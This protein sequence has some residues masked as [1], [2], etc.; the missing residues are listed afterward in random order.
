VRVWAL[1]CLL[2][3]ALLWALGAAS[4]S[5]TTPTPLACTDTAVENALAT[6]GDYQFNCS[7][8]IQ[9]GEGVNAIPLTSAHDTTIS[10]AA[11][12]TETWYDTTAE[13][14]FSTVRFINVTGGSLT[15]ND[16]NLTGGRYETSAG[17]TGTAGTSGT[18]G[19]TSAAGGNATTPGGTG[20]AGAPA[21]GGQIL[22]SP[23]AAVTLNGGTLYAASIYGGPGGGGGNGGSGG[24]GGSGPLGSPGASSASGGAGGSATAGGMGGAGGP[25]QGGSIYVSAG[26]TLNVSG[27]TFDTDGA[28]GGPGGSGGGGGHGGQ[29][30]SGGNDLES[31]GYG[32]A[33]GGKA[34]ST[35]GIGGT[36]GDAQGG[37]I[38]NAGT[39]NISSATFSNDSVGAAN[40]GNGGGGGAGGN[41]GQTSV[42]SPNGG[43]GG[44]A[45][46]G[47]FGGTGSGGAVYNA[48]GGTMTL[49][50]LTFSSDS[51]YGGPGGTG[52]MGGA[53]GCPNGCLSNGNFGGS[54][55]TNGTGGN[56][57]N[58]ATALDA[59]VGSVSTITGCLTFG[60]DSVHP[61]TAGTAGG[62]GIGGYNANPVNPTGAAGASGAAGTPGVVDPTVNG[63]A[64]CPT[65][66]VA[67]NSIL[68]PSTGQTAT[69]N[70][71]VTLSAA[72]QSTTT[73]Q[74]TTGDGSAAAGTDYTTASGTATIPAGSTTATIPVT[75][76][77]DSFEP[78]KTFTLTLTNPSPAKVTLSRATATGTIHGLSPLQVTVKVNPLSGPIQQD[79]AGPT[80][81]NATATVTLK[82]IGTTQLT[83]V[84]LPS[85]LTIGWHSGVSNTGSRPVIQA[86]APMNLNVGTLA[87]GAS[88]DLTP[89]SYTLQVSGD[90]DV[91]VQALATAAL[92]SATITGF[93][94]T[95]FKPD[96]QLLVFTAK[97]GAE[98]HSQTNPSLIQAGTSFLVNLTLE[99]RSN[100]RTIVVDPLYP[101]LDGNA[102]DGAVLPASVGYTGS[103]PTGAAAEVEASPY[104]E[105]KPGQ[106]AHYLTVV[107]TGASDAADT[108]TQVSGGTR[109]TVTFDPPTGSIVNTDNT[110]TAFDAAKYTVM[111]PGASNIQVGIDDSGMT[112]APWAASSPLTWLDATW[113]VSKGLTWGLWRATYGAVRGILWDLPSLVVKGIYNVSTA[114]LDYM[115]RMVELWTACDDKPSCKDDLVDTVADKIID[116][117]AQAPELLTQ[118]AAQL[119]TQVDSA[120]TSHFAKLE[121]EWDAGDWRDALTELTAEGTDTAINVALMLGPAVLA[122][123]PKAAAAWNSLKAATFAKVD[124][125]LAA[126]VRALEPAK[127]A[128]LAL[129]KVVKPGYWFT[130][131]QMASL[132]GVSDTE[133]SLLSAFTKRLGINVVLRSR[134]SQAIKYL[135]EGLAVVKP[136]WI[137]TKNVNELD[138]QFLGY[139]EGEL[140]RV[141]FRPP[142]SAST[143]ESRMTAQGLAKTDPE[144]SEVLSR[145][146]TRTKEY[147]GEY[148][149]MQK[150]NKAGKVRGK[151]PWGENG[152]NPAVQADTYSTVHFRLNTQGGAVVPEI[153]EGG[154]WKFITGDIDLIAITKANGSALSDAEHVS[155]LKQLSNIIG[156]QHPESATWINDGKFWFKA[157]KGYLTNEGE[158][159]LAQ[160]GPDGKIR[161]VE[162]NEKLSDPTSWSKLNYRI[163]WKGG[164][165]AGPGG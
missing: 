84:Q 36:G 154:K 136:Y 73:V 14:T 95:E 69:L 140:G 162:F 40:G 123:S 27:T 80:R 12:T 48:S 9:F 135:E 137:K 75:I 1:A 28:S 34:G 142:V 111:T 113:S 117:Y 11:N 19:G 139:D 20:S 138:V 134:A 63:S 99:N 17:G 101:G 60:G 158:C 148:K 143:A 13:G 53:A 61:G 160:Y 146:K 159:C 150:W 153:F 52:G 10:A 72:T 24:L 96:S 38:Y 100:Y 2:V 88:T 50:Q 78:N 109:A 128:F 93:G 90:G 35:G 144:W 66:S 126:T 70:F 56:G 46:T 121:A 8:Y 131:D 51:T 157:K 156:A 18:P 55:G 57:G 103:N 16:I 112:A 114:S 62:G 43:N 98:V 83:N 115:D 81:V 110:A 91:D 65:L 145:L 120:L 155:I 49:G 32:P 89:A 45:G 71:T 54:Y 47:G 149:Q 5:A 23:Q 30:G 85:Q 42:S 41:S 141:V 44:A 82:N 127:A 161:A 116:S 25:G 87:P 129:S 3:A 77:N 74:Y 26:G 125:A 130:E 76:L 79:A 21:Q 39:L 132:F 106:T 92:N 152:V 58:G 147:H 105:I 67:D 29:G 124:S 102:A 107:R 22:I 94:T 97:V 108:Q 7:S 122:R 68:E 6:G 86:A 33:G 133:S 104:I 4:A 64:A 37:A 165:E 164:Y 31:G 163:F 15:L 118:T 119:K 151:W 59:S